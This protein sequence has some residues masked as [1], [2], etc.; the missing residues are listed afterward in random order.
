MLH[1]MWWDAVAAA[2]PAGP[3]DCSV[4]RPSGRATPTMTS[5]TTCL[6][7]GGRGSAADM[8]RACSCRPSVDA[9]EQWAA[10]M[11]ISRNA[12]AGISA[13]PCTLQEHPHALVVCLMQRDGEHA[14]VQNMHDR[15]LVTFT[16]GLAGRPGSGAWGAD[17]T[18]ANRGSPASRQCSAGA[19]G[20]WLEPASTACAARR[21]TAGL[22]RHECGAAL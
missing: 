1:C 16:C 22:V 10:T 11:A 5:S 17:Y 18:E 8:P 20:W 14:R 9:V 3:P 7:G 6:P 21:S 15:V 4:S 2:L 13:R 19:A 12:V